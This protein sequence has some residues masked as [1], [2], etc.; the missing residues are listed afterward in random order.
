MKRLLILLLLS[1]LM[2]SS[3]SS[4]DDKE[5]DADKALT[6]EETAEPVE[7]NTTITVAEA[8]VMP[9]AGAARE[10]NVTREAEGPSSP[11]NEVP[12]AANEPS[13]S[14]NETPEAV[15]EVT[16]SENEASEAVDEVPAS[17]NSAPEAVDE[18]TGDA[19]FYYSEVPE[20]VRARMR[21][22]SYP[23]DDS[24]IRI[25]WDELRYLRLLYVDYSGVTK[26]GELVCHKKVA[27]DLLDIFKQL[28]EAGYGIN[29][30]ALVD[31]YN[32]DDDLSIAADNTSCF[33]YRVV[34]GSS[35]LSNHA[36][37]RAVDLNPLYNPCV[38]VKSGKVSPPAGTPYAD[39]SVDF[40][41]KIDENDLAFKL[42]TAHG[43]KWGGY[44]KTLKDYQHFEKEW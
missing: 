3:C 1:V 13:P 32:A 10:L 30:V 21:G 36:L 31:E 24:D 14:E 42:F 28:Y 5:K 40:P 33:N 9:E 37:G 27:D 12:E 6:A 29:Q 25:S 39:R 20:A 38:Y 16:P 19:D 4:S 11:E 22:L 41:H 18:V 8:P 43:F 23:A 15:D 26:T 17:E 34:A 2:L 44:W 35:K 7:E